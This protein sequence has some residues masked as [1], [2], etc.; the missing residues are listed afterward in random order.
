MTSSFK[1]AV[2]RYDIIYPLKPKIPFI[3]ERSTL[4]ATSLL[5]IHFQLLDLCTY[6]LLVHLIN[7]TTG[8]SL[9]PLRLLHL[10]FLLATSLSLSAASATELFLHLSAGCCINLVAPESC[11]APSLPQSV[12]VSLSLSPFVD[13]FRVPSFFTVHR[14]SSGLQCGSSLFLL[15]YG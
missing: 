12:S 4:E 5:T 10:F 8:P 2:N 14:S 15:I 7:R 9:F 1:S 3:N 11:G 6:R 13:L